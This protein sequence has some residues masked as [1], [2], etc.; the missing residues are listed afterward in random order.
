[1]PTFA[2][3]KSTEKWFIRTLGE[4]GW[5]PAY[6]VSQRLVSSLVEPALSPP[7]KLGA[8]EHGAFNQLQSMHVSFD[9]PVAP[10]QF[11]GR[12]SRR[13]V[14]LQ[15]CRERAQLGCFTLLQPVRKAVWL[16]LSQQMGKLTRLVG[17]WRDR[18]TQL[19]EGAH[20]LVV[21]GFPLGWLLE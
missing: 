8:T 18:R 3:S 6:A 14:P 15:T 9:R 12:A 16:A 4:H 13:F 19:F 10:G 5:E 20:Q 21:F 7:F 11:E 1:M 2:L 17:R